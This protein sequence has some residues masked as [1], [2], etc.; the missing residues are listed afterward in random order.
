MRVRK[1]NLAKS[2]ANRRYHLH[3]Q[4][5]NHGLAVNVS[6]R[7]INTANPP[8]GLPAKWCSELIKYSYHVQLTLPII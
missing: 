7:T 6:Q 3:R 8:S 1:I 2:E 5:K 4:L